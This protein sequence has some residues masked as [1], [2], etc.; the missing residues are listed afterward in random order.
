MGTGVE[1]RRAVRVPAELRI[2]FKHLGRPSETYADLTRNLSA[3]GVFVD[4]SV[5]LQTGVELALEIT[6][7]SGDKPIRMRA[8][9]VRVEEESGETGSDV[10][11]RTRGMALRFVQPDEAELDRLIDLARR[12]AARFK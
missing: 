10:A 11:V 9:V 5:G 6:L 4:T 8:E 3:G 12:H 1:R 2:E 7:G